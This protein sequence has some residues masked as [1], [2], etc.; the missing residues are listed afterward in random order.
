MEYVI[1]YTNGV[2]VWKL[3]V[4]PEEFEVLK[5]SWKRR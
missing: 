3:T 4:T 2:T 1:E 5:K